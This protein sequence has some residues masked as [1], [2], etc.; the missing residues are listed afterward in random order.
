MCKLCEN[1]LNKKD[2]FPNDNCIFAD[3]G[4]FYFFIDTGDSF[5]LIREKI[6]YCPIC[7]R[8]LVNDG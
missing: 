7:G 4:S 6:N 3:N 1:I 5:S 2:K 8:K